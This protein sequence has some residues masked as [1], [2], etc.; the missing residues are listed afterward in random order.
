MWSVTNPVGDAT[1]TDSHLHGHDHHMPKRY[2]IAAARN[3][4][5]RLV[6]EAEAGQPVELTRRGNAVAVVVSVAEY[7]QLAGKAP[8]L[9]DKVAEFRATYAGE[10]LGEVFDDVRNRSE[11]RRVEIHR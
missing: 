6:H 5:A 9:I 3:S 10:D 8:R 11:G 2:S 1:L 4:L 7:A